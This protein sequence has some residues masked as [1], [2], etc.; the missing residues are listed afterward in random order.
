LFVFQTIHL[1]DEHE[2]Y[3][4]DNQEVRHGVEEDAVID[5]GCTRSFGL[6]ER[7]EIDWSRAVVDGSSIRA[8]FG[9]CRRG[10]TLLTAPSWAAS[11]I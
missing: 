8:V 1:A 2:Y 7:G 6:G 3:E 4:S 9:G 5:R 11:A 10:R